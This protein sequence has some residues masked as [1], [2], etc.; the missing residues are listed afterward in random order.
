MPVLQNCAAAGQHD[1]LALV[2]EQ[3][4]G[5]E[6]RRAGRAGSGGT[7]GCRPRAG[8]RARPRPSGRPPGS[9]RH[10]DPPAAQ[11]PARPRLDVA[12]PA[13][14]RSCCGRVREPGEV[15]RR[16]DRRGA[17]A[18]DAARRCAAPGSRPARPSAAGRPRRTRA[19]RRRRRTAAGRAAGASVGWSVKYWATRR[20]F[21]ERCGSSAPGSAARASRNSS[22]SAVRM[23]VSPRQALR[24]SAHGRARRVPAGSR[25]AA[26]R[27]ARWWSSSAYSTGVKP[28]TDTCSRASSPPHSPLTSSTPTAT[29]R[30]PPPTWIA[31]RV[32][33]QPA[34]RAD[35]P[36]GAERDQRRTAGRARRSRP[37]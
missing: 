35:G 34:Q 15:A 20:W 7:R 2:A 17:Q 23:L 10:R 32:P 22:T 4:A 27:A 24:S 1:D 18:A 13:R 28:A 30:T 5:G 12:R 25:P 31:A 3:L 14:R 26:R 36:G 37:G 16:G 6:R 21:S 19:R 11:P 33:A 9:S 29:S 8:A